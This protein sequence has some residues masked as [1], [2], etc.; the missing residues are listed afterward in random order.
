M[1]SVLLAKLSLGSI[2]AGM[3]SVGIQMTAG[4]VTVLFIVTFFLG[5]FLGLLFEQFRKK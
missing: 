3:F 2:L 5:F 4:Q 1:F